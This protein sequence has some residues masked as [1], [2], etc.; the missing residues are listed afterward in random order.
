[1][2]KRDA[3]ELDPPAPIGRGTAARPRRPWLLV[4]DEPVAMLDPVARN[5][6]MATVMTA[7]ADDGPSEVTT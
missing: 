2:R 7:A 4:L 3:H 1:M 5:D 6:F